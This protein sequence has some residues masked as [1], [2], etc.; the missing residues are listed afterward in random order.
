[1]FESPDCSSC[2]KFATLSFNVVMFSLQG[3]NWLSDSTVPVPNFVIFYLTEHNQVI[4][5]GIAIVSYIL[6]A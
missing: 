3:K 2:E 1:M 5:E 4:W 6:P